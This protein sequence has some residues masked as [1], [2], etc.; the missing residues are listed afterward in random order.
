MDAQ[1][2]GSSISTVQF[3]FEKTATWV[4]PPSAESLLYLDISP[5]VWL[6]SASLAQDIAAKTIIMQ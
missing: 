1:D 5:S 4:L 6:Y 2:T 3:V